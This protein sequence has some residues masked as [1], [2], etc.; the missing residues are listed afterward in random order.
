ME[1]RNGT[2]CTWNLPWRGISG[3]WSG[4]GAEHAHMGSVCLYPCSFFL[5]FLVRPPRPQ[6]DH[7]PLI[8]H[9]SKFHVHAVPFRISMYRWRNVSLAVFEIY[10]HYSSLAT[11]TIVEVGG[12]D[13]RGGG[14]WIIWV[15][16]WCGGIKGDWLRWWYQLRWKWN[17]TV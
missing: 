5:F 7:L 1:M 6:P 11:V 9:Q 16:V 17:G 3:R 4:W 2:A 15:I 8:P 13:S 12:V 10:S 14:L